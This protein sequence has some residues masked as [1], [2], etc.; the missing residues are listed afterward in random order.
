MFTINSGD[1]K[2]FVIPLEDIDLDVLQKH[3]S[4]TK[5]GTTRP[6]W[7][8]NTLKKRHEDTYCEF[9]IYAADFGSH[10]GKF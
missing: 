10:N 9:E 7:D 3:Y 4:T 1:T 2:K 6:I 5:N 8:S